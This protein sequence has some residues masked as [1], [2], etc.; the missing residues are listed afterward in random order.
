MQHIQG[1]SRQQL[2]LERLEHKISVD[3]SVR[4]I[5]AIPTRNFAL[6]IKSKHF[7]QNLITRSQN[8]VFK[9]L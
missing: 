6:S 8:K 7:A 9:L 2:Q 1:I 5:D 3:N 4:F